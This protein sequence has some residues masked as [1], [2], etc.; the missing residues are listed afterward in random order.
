MYH[1]EIADIRCFFSFLLKNGRHEKEEEEEEEEEAGRQ[2]IPFLITVK[3]K[4][5]GALAITSNKKKK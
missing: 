2:V 5:W 1:S 4:L 3:D